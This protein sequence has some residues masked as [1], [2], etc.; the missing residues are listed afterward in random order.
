MSAACFI[1]LEKEIDGL[2]S[3]PPLDGRP[4]ARAQQKLDRIAKRLR[5]RP[6][7]GFVLSEADDDDEMA[8]LDEYYDAAL[9]LRTVR[10]L[11]RHVASNPR[12][13]PRSVDVMRDLKS[14]EGV[15]KLAEKQGV[16]F[17]LGVDV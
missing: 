1:S 15:L 10:A 5:V 11:I 13:V 2:A 12:E 4:L 9:G 16:R 6:L 7:A 3:A 14:L 17:S 8:E